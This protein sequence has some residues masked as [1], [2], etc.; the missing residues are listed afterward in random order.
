[1]KS[2]EHFVRLVAR[3]AG[4]TTVLGLYLCLVIEVYGSIIDALKEWVK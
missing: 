3:V 2:R 4:G 1:M